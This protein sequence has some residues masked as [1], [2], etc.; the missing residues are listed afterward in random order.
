M[1]RRLFRFATILSVLVLVCIAVPAGYAMYHGPIIVPRPTQTAQRELVLYDMAMDYSW[2]EQPRV[3]GS[4]PL[5]TTFF[6]DG[7]RGSDDGFF[8]VFVVYGRVYQ[9]AWFRGARP[10]DE[11]G[12]VLHAT[13]PPDLML[14]AG[15]VHVDYI[16]LG[17]L[18]SL[19]PLLA[20]VR[21]LTRNTSVR[22]GV[23]FVSYPL[24]RPIA[25]WL[26]DAAPRFLAIVEASDGR[27]RRCGYDLR[28]TPDHC[29]ECGTAAS[30]LRTHAAT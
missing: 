12:E 5:E 3:T 6:A 8:D 13:R 28:A 2:G 18:A 23:R 16:R 24:L 14:P 1:R 27:C 19:L 26:A 30:R 21:W 9:L 10:T 29:P 4:D 7:R 22:R 15:H 17:A 25:G 11:A 20:L